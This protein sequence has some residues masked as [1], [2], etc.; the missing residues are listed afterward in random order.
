MGNFILT[1]YKISS[2]IQLIFSWDTCSHKIV[3]K[4]TRKNESYRNLY[5]QEK[6]FLQKFIVA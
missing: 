2:V 1:K 6:A 3:L 5:T 4:K